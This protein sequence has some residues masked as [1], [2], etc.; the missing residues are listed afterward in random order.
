MTLFKEY[1]PIITPVLLDMMQQS[2]NSTCDPN[3]MP[4]LLNKEACE[5]SSVVKKS[6]YCL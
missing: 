2:D 3:N 4:S 5:L 6:T 1:K